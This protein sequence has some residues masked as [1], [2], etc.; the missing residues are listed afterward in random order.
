MKPLV[1]MFAAL[2]LAACGQTPA[3]PAG[4]AEKAPAAAMGGMNGKGM[5]MAGAAMATG[6][7]T[8]TAIDKAA[9]TITLDHGPIAEVGWPAMTMAFEVAPAS[10]LDAVKVGDRVRF[11]MR[12]VGGTGQ[13]TAL[14]PQ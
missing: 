13:I 14:T 4:D 11:E 10:L 6:S 5:D 1:P 7:G 8:V 9:G 2:A 3:K 12:M